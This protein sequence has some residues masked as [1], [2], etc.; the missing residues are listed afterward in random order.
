M[1]A[2]QDFVYTLK[3]FILVHFAIRLTVHSFPRKVLDPVTRQMLQRR[4][5]HSP[6]LV[7]LT[8]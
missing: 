3:I 7:I 2:P 8:L 6:F 1:V 4:G 5:F